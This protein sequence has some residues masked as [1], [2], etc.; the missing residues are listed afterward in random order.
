[1]RILAMPRPGGSA[2]WV[3]APGQSTAVP[4]AES[5]RGFSASRRNVSER[6]E[7]RFVGSS[8]A[9]AQELLRRGRRKTRSALNSLGVTERRIPWG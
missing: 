8:G 2:G 4:S 5:L 7:V 3:A 9:S 1:M 6:G